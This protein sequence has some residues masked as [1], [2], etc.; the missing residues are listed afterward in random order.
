MDA[1]TFFSAAAALLMAAVL[2]GA[3]GL[4]QAGAAE[5]A[6]AMPP[7]D[8]EEAELDSMPAPDSAAGLENEAFGEGPLRVGI[9]AKGELNDDGATAARS[10]KALQAAF[11]PRALDVRYLNEDELIAAVMNRE[12]D[13][14]TV[15]SGFFS[16]L[17]ATGSGASLLAR[18]KLPQAQSPEAE[19]GAVFIVRAGDERFSKLE[20]LRTARVVSASPQSF[21][22]W[23]AALGEIA[24]IT[25]YPKNF[26]GKVDFAGGDERLIVDKVLSKSYD[27]GVLRACELEQLI[28]SGAVAPS[29]IRVVGE[30]NRPELSCKVST[31]LWPGPVF[32]ARSGLPADLKRRAAVALLTMPPE[33][34]YAWTVGNLSAELDNLTRLLGVVPDGGAKHA[35]SAALDR[36]KYALLIGILLLGAACFYSVA[37]SQVVA[38]RTKE[39]TNVIHE[40]TELEKHA[41][42][43]R[44]RLSQLERAGIVAELS[45]MIAHELRQP[46]SALVN[47]SD[48]LAL[49]LSGQKDDP[50]IGEAT[51]G[52]ASQAE[53]ISSIVERVRAYAKGSAN[54]H[55]TVDLGAVAKRAF[56]TVRS[57]SDLT[58]VRFS[59]DLIDGAWVK[60]DPLELELLVVN[61][62][63]NS[64][65]SIRKNDERRGAIHIAIAPHAEE[66][67]E[68]VAEQWML[69]VVDD[70]PKIDDATFAELSHPVTS[71]K[72]EG[73]GLGLSIC[74]VIAER[75]V[76]RLL[77]RRMTP[78]GLAAKLLLPK[79]DA[80]APR[81]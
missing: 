18:L 42:D 67:G 22:G 38:R 8:G 78:K 6:A 52:I 65:Q 70:G 35:S 43:D 63:K 7:M 14:Y 50:V 81:S 17:T 16:Y 76:G 19:V 49:Y 39:L 74:R 9:F 24:N 47:Y 54:V 11:A 44:E 21:G 20:D 41:K 77:F 64:L 69:T 58:G 40:K 23:I 15:S 1:K 36:Y 37:V 62:I 31:A 79:A 53:R 27:V 10:A 13:L 72:L 60:G 51:R 2:G 32:A 29:A 71:E 4:P 34:G 25:K 59:A 3:A 5:L 28:A 30:K 68:T 55:Q 66:R 80:P 48:G 46:V 12:L 57:G 61:L 45:S 26:F 73:L 75:H 56:M 33:A